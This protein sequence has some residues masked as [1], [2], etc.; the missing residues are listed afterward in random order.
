MNCVQSLSIKDESMAEHIAMSMFSY[1][2]ILLFSVTKRKH[3]YYSQLRLSNY[4][5]NLS[6]FHW[7]KQATRRKMQSDYGAH[8]MSNRQIHMYLIL[9]EKER[10]WTVSKALGCIKHSFGCGKDLAT[11]IWHEIILT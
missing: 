2:S 3:Q 9:Y 10:P 11:R 6:S 4:V 8:S 7:M 1:S 5:E